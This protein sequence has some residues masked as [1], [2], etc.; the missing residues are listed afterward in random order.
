MP[1]GIDSIKRAAGDVGI[2]QL[3]EQRVAREVL[4]GAGV[5]VAGAQV[6]EAALAVAVRA[7]VAKGVGAATCDTYQASGFAA[8]F[9][10]QALRSGNSRRDAPGRFR[11]L[12][13]RC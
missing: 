11:P 7:G 9:N 3:G 13:S 10:P 12:D 6:V 1:T 2:G 4:L 8:K 5:V